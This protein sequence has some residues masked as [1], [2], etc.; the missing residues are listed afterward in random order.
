V[1]RALGFIRLQFEY[2]RDYL[3]SCGQ[4]ALNRPQGRLPNCPPARARPV[5]SPAWHDQRDLP[6][7]PACL[8][9]RNID[10]IQPSAPLQDWVVGA[11]ASAGARRGP[12]CWVLGGK[13]KEFQGG[14]RSRPNGGPSNLTLCRKNHHR[15]QRQQLQRPAARTISLGEQ[16]VERAPGLRRS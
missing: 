7:K 12:T 2:G 13:T 4:E 6:A 3:L 9:P 8:V 15:A 1:F 14:D 10:L 11:Q 5:I 16:S